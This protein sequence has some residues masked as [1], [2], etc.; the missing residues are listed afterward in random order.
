MRLFDKELSAQDA[1][2]LREAIEHHA[3]AAR[4]E[5]RR[6]TLRRMLRQ[7]DAG[8]LS[9]TDK[10]ERGALIA[11]LRATVIFLQ[12]Q[13]IDLLLAGDRTTGASVAARAQSAWHMLS[14]TTVTR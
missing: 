6:E 1:A 7:V 8:K 10:E 5:T 9:P 4:Y 13:A 12:K 11:V 14:T 3:S 2:V